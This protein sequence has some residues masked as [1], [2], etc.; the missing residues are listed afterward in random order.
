MSRNIEYAY[1]NGKFSEIPNINT[2]QI[3]NRKNKRFKILSPSGN[4]IHFGLYPYKGKGTYIDHFDTKIRKAWK[5]RHSKI[6]KDGKPAYLNPESPEY[7]SW[8]ILW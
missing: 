6:L 7:Y 5:A 3:S 1:Y 8:H 2:L 4:Y